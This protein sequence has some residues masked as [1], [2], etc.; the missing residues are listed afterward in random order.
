MFLFNLF[1]SVWE[2]PLRPGWGNTLTE[3]EQ[4]KTAFEI[5]GTPV[6]WYAIMILLAIVLSVVIGYFGFAKRLGATSDYLFEGVAVGVISG[7]AGGRLWYVI[8]DIIGG[9][10]SFIQPTIIDTLKAILNLRTGGLAISGAVILAGIGVFLFCRYRKIKVLYILE[11]VM[12]LIMLSQVLGR[13]GNFF[14][15]EAHGPLINVPGLQEALANG[16]SLPDNILQAQRDFLWFLPDFIIDRMYI[17]F[18]VP[19]AGYYHPCFFYE[20]VA[21]FIGFTAYMIIRRV[22]KKGIYVGDGIGFYL[23]WYGVVRFFIEMLRTDAQGPTGVKLVMIYTPIMVVLGILWLVLRRVMKIQLIT[24]YE[25][26]YG[27]DSTVIIDSTN[28]KKNKKNNVKTKV[29][30]KENENVES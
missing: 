2:D 10:K 26:L 4:Y 14:N 12:P 18:D 17:S 3:L 11:I 9:G 24:C 25:A 15:F 29:I 16:G 1:G 20:G 19:I 27:F 7:I 13:W 28:I 8:A 6:A 21:N 22:V 23:I 30:E 5:F